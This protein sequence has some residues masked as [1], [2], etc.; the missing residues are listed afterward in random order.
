MVLPLTTRL[1]S[2]RHNAWLVGNES[3][4][5]ASRSPAQR[6]GGQHSTNKN[7]FPIRVLVTTLATTHSINQLL[8]LTSLQKHCVQWQHHHRCCFSLNQLNDVVPNF[9]KVRSPN[10][11]RISTVRWAVT[12]KLPLENSPWNGLYTP[13]TSVRYS[14]DYYVWCTPQFMDTDKHR[15]SVNLWTR[16]WLQTLV[17]HMR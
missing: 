11:G 1:R 9:E 2:W 7:L 17:F 14:G 4:R 16:R 15:R 3:R 8:L 10:F 5:S 6:A 13:E 12:G